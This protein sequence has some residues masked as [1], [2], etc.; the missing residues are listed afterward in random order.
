MFKINFIFAKKGV[1]KYISHLDLM[2]LFARGLRRTGLLLKMTEGYSPHIKL[3]LKRALKL[4]L[5]SENEEATVMLRQVVSPEDFCSLLQ[6]ALPE[7]IV[8]KSAANSF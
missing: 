5:E 2:R 8:I 6:K 1:L 3:S 7:G 4:G